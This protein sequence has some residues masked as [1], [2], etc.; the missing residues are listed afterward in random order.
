MGSRFV[1]DVLQ[2]I[3]TAAISIMGVYTVLWG[4]WVASP[5]WDAFERAEAFSIMA[6]V[7]PEHVW[8]VVALI[9]GCIMIRGVMKRSYRA[10]TIGALAGF[11][12]WITVCGF[13]FFGD[14]Q[15]TGGIT[16]LMIAAYCGFIWLNLRVNKAHFDV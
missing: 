7:A 12:Q 15:N 16:Y 3:N 8:G 2:P 11:F 4:I 10:L 9:V 1:R 6:H 5:F 13:F 14:W